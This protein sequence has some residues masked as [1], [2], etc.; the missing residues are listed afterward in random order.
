[1]NSKRNSF[2]IVLVILICGFIFQK[3][4]INEF[5][6]FIHAWAQSDRYA[7][8][9]GFLNNNFD[10]FHPQTFV[11][12]HQFP[13][14]Y[15]V[16]SE[17]G[18][19]SVDFPIHDY[20]PALLMGI[21]HT[22]SPWCFRLYILMY[23]FIGLFFLYKITTLFKYD[24]FTSI[25]LILFAATSPVFVYYQAGFLP[26]I[27]S[28]ANGFIGLFYFIKYK[29]QN[30]NCPYYWSILF[31]TLAALSRTPFSILLLSVVINELFYFLK[32]KKFCWSKFYITLFYYCYRLFF[33]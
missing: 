5:P 13:G 15:L 22:T 25:L 24:L 27:P 29:T 1:M 33:I 11:L 2:I 6:S 28:L 17:N 31:L 16:P 23:S 7:L 8:A 18:I 3:K 26:S 10:F 19:T 9:L 14:N 21:F 20:I 4:Y 30:N 12:N 32:S